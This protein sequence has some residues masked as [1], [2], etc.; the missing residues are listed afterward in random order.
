[1]KGH[2]EKLSRKQELAV[3]ALL[4]ESTIA[5]AAQKAGVGEV[6]LWRWLKQEGFTSVYRSARRE[7][8]EKAIAQLQQ[9]SWAAATTLLNLLEAEAESIRLRT[10]V[11]ILDHAHKAVELWDIEERLAALEGLVE[12]S[13]NGRKTAWRG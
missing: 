9:A 12:V 10:A 11:A 2:G 13:S 5:A 3:A 7:T 4:T 8:V 6:T 1:M